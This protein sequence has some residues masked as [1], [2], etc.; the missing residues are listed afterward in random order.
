MHIE[1]T[2][3]L[4][5]NLSVTVAEVSQRMLKNSVLLITCCKNPILHHCIVNPNA[6]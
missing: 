4:R 5:Y 1:Y 2:V 6:R 3:A